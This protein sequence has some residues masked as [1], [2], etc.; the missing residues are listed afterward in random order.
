MLP[1]DVLK[2]RRQTKTPTNPSFPTSPWDG[3]LPTILGYTYYGLSVYPTYNLLI[4]VLSH[5]PFHTPPELSSLLAGSAAAVVACVG[6]AP[7][8][9]IRI[10]TVAE[11]WVYKDLSLP[12]KASLIGGLGPLYKGFAPLLVRQVCFGTVKFAAFDYLLA[13]ILE[14]EALGWTER[15]GWEASLIAG[16]GA[17]LIGAVV[18]QP[19][20]AVLTWLA[21]RDCRSTTI[22]AAARELVSRRGWG[23]L[24]EGGGERLAW[25][26]FIIGAQFAA[27]DA[28]R[29]AMGAGEEGIRQA[30]NAANAAS[31]VVKL[32]G[33]G[34]V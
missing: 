34:G 8:E 9:V 21:G 3:A 15:G 7:M 11:P 12:E 16:V 14:S 32:V 6:L 1:L 24:G 26:G 22:L 5:P 19:A 17:G 13:S 30:V 18:S 31:E 4:R 29:G 33:Q 27:Y 25:A 28:A 20:D 10:R 23:S 2:T